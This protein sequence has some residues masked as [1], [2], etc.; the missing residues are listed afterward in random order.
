M[1]HLGDVLLSL[2]GPPGQ[3]GAI[4][5]AAGKCGQ[6]VGTAEAEP[7][8]HSQGRPARHSEVAKEHPNKPPA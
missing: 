2:S 4:G 3:V 8:D 1:K 5:V 6:S 7:A